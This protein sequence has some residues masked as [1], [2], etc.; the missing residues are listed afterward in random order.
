MSD[1]DQNSA[2][3]SACS[4]ADTIRH[5]RRRRGAACATQR[6]A[7]SWAGTPVDEWYETSLVI[8]IG[9]AGLGLGR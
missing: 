6:S 9:L 7:S 1:V 4:L 8:V 2:S 3:H 5:L